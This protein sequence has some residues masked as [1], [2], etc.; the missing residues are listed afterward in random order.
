ML[1]GNLW[2]SPPPPLQEEH[3]DPI[4]SGTGEA[5]GNDRE[6]IML[7]ENRLSPSSQVFE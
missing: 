4:S 1:E 5:L 3:W 6:M 7:G 2:P